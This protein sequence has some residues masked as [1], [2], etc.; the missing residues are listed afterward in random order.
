MTKQKKYWKGLAELVNDPVVDKL[1]EN[2]FIE[3]IPVD[4]FL[5]DDKNLS[6][7]ST[8]RR[9]FLK[10]LGFSTAAATLA[11]CETPIIKSIP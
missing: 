9:D 1:K 11:A 10:F 3:E 7:K 2:E 8:S 6:E 5:G 4:D